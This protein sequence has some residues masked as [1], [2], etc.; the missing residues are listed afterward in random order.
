[1]EDRVEG[2]AICVIFM[3]W[4]S[5]NDQACY[6]TAMACPV[7]VNGICG[8]FYTVHVPENK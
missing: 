2:G 6:T 3:E 1:M 7:R 8:L 5:I 4:R